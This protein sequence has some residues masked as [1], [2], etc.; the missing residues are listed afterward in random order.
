MPRALGTGAQ[1]RP[2]SRLVS[3]AAFEV[4][5][6]VDGECV[7]ANANLLENRILRAL[8][9][10]NQ[11]AELELVD[12]RCFQ[13]EL[14]VQPERE[15]EVHGVQKGRGIESR[16]GVWK[17]QPGSVDG[18][19]KNG[20]ARCRRH[21]AFPAPLYEQVGVGVA[22]LEIEQLLRSLLRQWR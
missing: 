6:A 10:E 3:T 1:V 22:D 7:V 11:R 17:R 19:R 5:I 4:R 13:V 18:L 21:G 16:E 20:E 2:E 15:G 12:Y 8:I 9:P 14:L